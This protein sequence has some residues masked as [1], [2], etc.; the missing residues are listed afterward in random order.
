MNIVNDILHEDPYVAV[1]DAF[2]A[3]QRQLEDYERER[4]GDVKRHAP[5][6]ARITT[7]PGVHVEEGEDQ[8]PPEPITHPGPVS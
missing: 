3:V 8:G 6:P 7:E 5:E 1:R 4:R 2:P